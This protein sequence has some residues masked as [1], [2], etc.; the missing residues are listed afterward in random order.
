MK[1]VIF[2]EET[3]ELEGQALQV[4]S[5][6]PD[7]RLVT[8]DLQEVNLLNQNARYQVISTLPTLAGPVCSLQTK[9][10]NEQ[11]SKQ[12]LI[13]F[14]VVS[15]DLPFAQGQFCS[16]QGIKDLKILSDFRYRA[17][18]ERYGV[19]LGKGSLQGLLARA[20]F[21]VD[22]HGVIVYKEIVRNLLE[23]PN[24]EALLEVLR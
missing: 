23:E 5:N 19:L 16:T 20:V 21:V 8:N 11:A 7:V 4:G 9:K 22:S 18:G 17:F 6:A 12:S 14:S 13:S 10:F 2:N 3:Y 24:Y 1:K 15:M